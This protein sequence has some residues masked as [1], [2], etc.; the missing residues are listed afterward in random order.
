M[1]M[2]SD[3]KDEARGDESQRVGYRR[4]PVH[5]RFKPGQSGNPS[6]R[7]KGSKNLRRLFCK[8][9]NEEIALR[10]GA[11]VRTVTKGE[12]I[13]RS[14][15]VG[16]LKGDARNLAALLRLAEQ[17]GQLQDDE[18]NA[19]AAQQII[20]TWRA[21]SDPADAHHTKDPRDD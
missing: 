8:L 4:P 20:F 21:P 15:I 7:P 14:V 13:L 19:P 9:L 3:H 5:S 11:A 10:E 6:G 17:T 18:H 12:A 1:L 16:A 2:K